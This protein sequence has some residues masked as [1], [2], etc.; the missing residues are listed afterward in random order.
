MLAPEAE[1]MAADVLSPDELPRF[2]W[3]GQQPDS[4]TYTLTLLRAVA[5]RQKWRAKYERAK[6]AGPVD[7]R[8]AIG[9]VPPD[10]G[11]AHFSAS[12]DDPPHSGRR[13]GSQG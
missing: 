6:A 4:T 1:R 9:T 2:I 5:E 11:P 13:A 7:N 8:S 12:P 10:R 3:T